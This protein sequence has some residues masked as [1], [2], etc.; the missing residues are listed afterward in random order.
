MVKFD[1][2]ELSGLI[3]LFIGVILLAFTFFSAYLFL[4]GELSILVTGDLLQSFGEA[5]APLI[6]AII[7]VLFLGIMGWI[8]SIVT[9]RAVQLL[10]Q[11]KMQTTQQNPAQAQQQPTKTEPKQSTPQPGP[12]PPTQAPPVEAKPVAEET[13]K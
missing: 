7:H 5:L 10:K 4:T 8:G 12:A 9:I 1:K 11:D 13:K 2:V 3:V 6:E